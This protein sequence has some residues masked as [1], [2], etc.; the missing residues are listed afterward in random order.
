MLHTFPADHVR[1]VN[2]VF[3]TF[4]RAHQTV[5]RHQDTARKVVKLLL[6]LLPCTAKISYQMRIFF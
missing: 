4:P 6:L 2:T 1:A 3:V 5:C